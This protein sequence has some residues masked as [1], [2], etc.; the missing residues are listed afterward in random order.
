[1]LPLSGLTFSSF[2]AYFYKLFSQPVANIAL[3]DDFV[4]FNHYFSWSILPNIDQPQGFTLLTF[5]QL[6]QYLLFQGNIIAVFKF[7]IL[8]KNVDEKNK[9]LHD[10]LGALGSIIFLV[11]E[12]HW[13]RTEHVVDWTEKCVP[14]CSRQ[15]PQLH[16]YK[17]QQIIPGAKMGIF[18]TVTSLMPPAACSP[19]YALKKKN[20]KLFFFFFHPPPPLVG[21]S[22][23]SAEGPVFTLLSCWPYV[24]VSSWRHRKLFPLWKPG[25]NRN[26]T[27]LC[28]I[29]GKISVLPW[30]GFT[31]SCLKSLGFKRPKKSRV[32]SAAA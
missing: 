24:G 28:T 23:L 18:W 8:E 11:S 4:T 1:M 17:H 25:H 15:K 16:T 2:L 13:T 12:L 6:C 7:Y 29:R 22:V 10:S 26:H 9:L 27:N 19:N 31:W 5:G 20:C 3:S 32:K 21:P 30:G 14:P